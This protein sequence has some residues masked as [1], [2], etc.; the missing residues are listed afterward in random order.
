MKTKTI[1]KRYF[2]EILESGGGAPRDKTGATLKAITSNFYTLICDETKRE[3]KVKCTQ[4]CPVHFKVYASPK[5]EVLRLNFVNHSGQGENATHIK[6]IEAFKISK[7]NG[8][9]YCKKRGWKVNFFDSVLQ[10]KSN[11]LF[12]FHMNAIIKEV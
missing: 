12:G 8:L 2:D 10:V 9:E 7:D 3:L 1:L 6:V 4:D 5:I 11:A